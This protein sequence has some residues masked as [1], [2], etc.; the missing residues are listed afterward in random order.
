MT[1]SL[2]LSRNRTTDTRLV[3]RLV[4]GAILP[5][6][7][8]LIFGLLAAGC[9]PQLIAHR[10]QQVVDDIT[11]LQKQT[12]LFLIRLQ[13]VCGTPEGAYASNAARHDELRAAAS[14]LQVQVNATPKN[15]KTAEQVALLRDSYDKLEALHK[16]GCVPAAL[17]SARTLLNSQFTALITLEEAKAKQP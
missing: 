11:A 17:E 10:N 1:A 12:D 6:L 15:A 4:A 7:L 14:S 2:L 5:W 16:T 9:T 8:W 13:R 3:R